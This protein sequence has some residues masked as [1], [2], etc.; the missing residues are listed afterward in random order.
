MC[1]L[2]L[3]N[4]TIMV[5]SWPSP[6]VFMTNTM[7][8]DTCP[9]NWPSPDAEPLGSLRIKAEALTG[10]Y[11]SKNQVLQPEDDGV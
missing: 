11:S 4:I 9:W 3:S 7:S 10:G 8:F 1:L 5:N 2:P 6:C